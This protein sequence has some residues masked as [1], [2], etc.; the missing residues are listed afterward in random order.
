MLESERAKMTDSMTTTTNM[1]Q[2]PPYPPPTLTRVITCGGTNQYCG[3][4][5]CPDLTKDYTHGPLQPIVTCGGSLTYCGHPGCPD[6]TQWR[7]E[8]ITTEE[9][10]IEALETIKRMKEYFDAHPVDPAAPPGPLIATATCGGT[11]T[12]CGHPWCKDMTKR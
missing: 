8:C 11:L 12:Y 9:K 3:H 4:P 7:K 1:T 5:G 2:V 6:R 10:N